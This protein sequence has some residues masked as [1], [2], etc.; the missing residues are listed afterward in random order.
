MS[1]CSLPLCS[2]YG[3]THH[4][5]SHREGQHMHCCAAHS[6]RW[7]VNMCLPDRVWTVL[8]S[9]WFCL[10]VLGIDARALCAGQVFYHWGTCPAVAL[11]SL[12]C[13]YLV[14]N[15]E[16]H[17]SHSAGRNPSLNNAWMVIESDLKI[18]QGLANVHTV[19]RI[20]GAGEAPFGQKAS[21]TRGWCPRNIED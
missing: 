20:L 11:C 2:C 14:R 8:N 18:R 15:S 16:Q 9:H 1:Q 17:V 7:A 21:G 5:T 4:I 6:T 19:E 12:C 13:F 3:Q 10:V